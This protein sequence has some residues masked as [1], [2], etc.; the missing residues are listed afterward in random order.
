MYSFK[1]DYSE[2]A[3]PNIM[4][5]LL[6]SNLEQTVGYGMDSCCE[7][8]RRSICEK[9]GRQD[10]D[11]HFLVGGTQTNLTVISAALRPYQAVI[12]AETG[13]ICVHETGA[14]EAAGHK[15]IAV[16]AENG[17]LTPQLIHNTIDVHTDEHM[18]QPKMVYLSLP[19]E[20]GTI[21]SKQELE[22][23]SVCCKE[24]GLLLYVDGARLASAL[25]AQGC[26]VTLAD[27]ARLCDA[28]YIGGTKCGALFGEA[29]VLLNNAMKQDF[30][31]MIKQRGGMLAKG[32][33][34]GIQFGELFRDDLY[35]RIGQHANRMAAL[36]KQACQS[37]G[38]TFVTDS[39]TNQQFPI[40]P[41]TVL[42]EMEKNYL[43]EVWEKR[44]DGYTAVRFVTSWATC[45][46]NVLQFCADLH[47]ACM[48]RKA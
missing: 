19:T 17:K 16:A 33:L 12:S 8:A 41:D 31:Y 47:N 23:I 34:L 30:R 24:N 32:R 15:V 45:E 35:Y 2:G 28:F 10:A 1:N 25:T 11:V 7:D 40:L 36:I 44:N 43:F 20:V 46:E 14:I 5:A 48:S 4:Q 38:F 27:L 18:V 42:E 6:K 9:I 37:E 29:V 21:Y 26:D 13:H 39:V 22:D 3:H